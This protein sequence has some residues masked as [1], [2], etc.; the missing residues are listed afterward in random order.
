TDADGDSLTVA[1]VSGPSHGALTLNGG[2][3]FTYT[4]VAGYTGSDSFTYQ[5]SD[6]Q[7]DSNVA[8]V[9]LA[10]TDDAPVANDDSYTASKNNPLTVAAHGALPIDSDANGDALTAAV[11]SGPAHGTLTLN[12]DGS[13]TY[14]PAAGYTGSDSF[15]Y[16]ASD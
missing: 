10:V 5:A 13:F 3:S 14:T 12:G 6:G 7:L 9:T 4:P 15:T 1:L 2:G 16:Q 8:T 11:V